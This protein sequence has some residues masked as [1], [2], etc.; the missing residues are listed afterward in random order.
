MDEIKDMVDSIVAGDNN[1][2]TDTFKDVLGNKLKDSL[3][4]R[5]Q[6]LAK[7]YANEPKDS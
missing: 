3:D 4:N 6:E 7:D 1:K 2:A 5:R